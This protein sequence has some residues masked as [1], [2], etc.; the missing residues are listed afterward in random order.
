MLSF[1]KSWKTI[2]LKTPHIT[3]TFELHMNHQVVGNIFRMLNFSIFYIF[4]N[5]FMANSNSDT[6]KKENMCVVEIK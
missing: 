3:V 1:K 6:I 5:N 2:I 4:E